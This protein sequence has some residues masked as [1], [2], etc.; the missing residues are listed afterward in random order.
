MNI[1]DG[2]KRVTPS[3]HLPKR[4]NGIYEITIELFPIAYKVY[5]FIRFY[6]TFIQFLFDFHFPFQLA[7]GHCL[8]L[9]IASGAHPFRSR[10]PGTG[11]RHLRAFHNGDAFVIIC[12]LFFYQETT[13]TMPLRSSN[14]TRKSS[15]H[16]RVHP[17]FVCLRC[18]FSMFYV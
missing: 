14:W 6:S 16:L 3:M 1:C 11:T 5:H 2:F 18:L 4:E 10:N 9:Q 17:L 7:E 13:F 15:P 12:Y 8:T